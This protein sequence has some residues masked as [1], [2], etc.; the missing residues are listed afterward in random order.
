M[1]A[2]CTNGLLAKGTN[3]KHSLKLY[4]RT[5]A[6][7]SFDIPLSQGFKLDI[8][9]SQSAFYGKATTLEGTN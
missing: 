1:P 6:K 4:K 7:L 9:G 2:T 3:C 8:T 5:T